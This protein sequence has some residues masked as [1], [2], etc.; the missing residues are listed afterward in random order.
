MT[1]HAETLELF[2]DEALRQRD[3]GIGFSPR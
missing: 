1:L 2:M 3:A